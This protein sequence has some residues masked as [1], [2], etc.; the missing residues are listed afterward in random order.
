M[1][2]ASGTGSRKMTQKDKPLA[3]VDVQEIAWRW[4]ELTTI[5]TPDMAR[6]FLSK[7]HKNRVVSREHLDKIKADILAGTWAAAPNVIAF[8][9]AGELIDGQHR[10]TAIA[11]TNTPVPCILIGGFPPE[12]IDV[13]DTGRKRTISD[14]LAIK[15]GLHTNIVGAAVRHIYWYCETQDPKFSIRPLTNSIVMAAFPV[16]SE[17]FARVQE[18]AQMAHLTRSVCSASFMT[19]VMFLGCAARHRWDLG[20]E[21]CEG[22][23]TGEELAATDPRLVFRNRMLQVRASRMKLPLDMQFALIIRTWNAFVA[24]RP[25]AKIAVGKDLQNIE[26][27]GIDGCP[28]GMWP[29]DVVI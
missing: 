15:G 29:E 17:R 23:Q 7:Q 4:D 6:Q 21:F 27:P 13:I 28:R 2:L 12:T 26:I 8:N 19:T 9:E 22:I 5:V 18:A 14:V 16:A 3:V 20:R 25:M 1:Q 11:D 10:C 24:G